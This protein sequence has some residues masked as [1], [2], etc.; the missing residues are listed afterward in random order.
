[1]V[2]SLIGDAE[3]VDEVIVALYSVA[4]RLFP[5][6]PCDVS[7][8]VSEQFRHEFLDSEVPSEGKKTQWRKIFYRGHLFRTFSRVLL[9]DVACNWL[10]CFPAS[11]RKHVYDVFFLKGS[12]AEVVQVMVPCLQCNRSSGQNQIAV[13][14]NVERLIEYCFLEN[15]MAYQVA[16][17]IAGAS[18]YEKPNRHEQLKQIAQLMTSIPDKA[19]LGASASF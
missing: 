7:G 11:A 15:N 18:E 16:R 13:S 3:N 1:C 8:S 10:A 5:L 6:R 19:R 17:E 14:M 4:V 12:A 9:Y 2:I